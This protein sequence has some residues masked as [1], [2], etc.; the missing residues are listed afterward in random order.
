M[1]HRDYKAKLVYMKK[2]YAARG[3]EFRAK[4]RAEYAANPDK[5]KAEAAAWRRANPE[6]SKE[7]AKRSAAKRDPEERRRYFRAYY[8]RCKQKALASARRRKGLPTPSRSAP[9]V[10][11]CCGGP[12]GKRAMVLDHC[13][14][15]G[16]FRGWL[17]SPCNL[18]IGKL[19]DAL[20]SLKL[21]VAYLER[22]Q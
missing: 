13:H 20:T 6:K 8:Q 12:S 22:A 9:S 11:E 18:G 1:P 21:A 17:C 10:C 4:R 2:R 3:A 7:T 19:G 15:T 16:K 14:A 5:F